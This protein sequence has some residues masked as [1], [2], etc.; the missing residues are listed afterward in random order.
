MMKIRDRKKGIKYSTNS[1]R[2]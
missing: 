2:S 1:S